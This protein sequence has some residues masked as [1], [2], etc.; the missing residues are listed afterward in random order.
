MSE[1]RSMR[2]GPFGW[3][4]KRTLRLIRKNCDPSRNAV[5]VYLALCEISSTRASND[6]TAPLSLIGEYARIASRRVL[7]DALDQLTFLGLVEV[8]KSTALRMASAYVLLRCE[9]DN[10]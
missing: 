3:W 9:A 10:P 5:S 6:F 2:D 8:H 7:D 1:Q 4:D